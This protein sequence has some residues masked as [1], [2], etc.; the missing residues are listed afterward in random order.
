MKPF[1]A[2]IKLVSFTFIIIFLLLSNHIYS[3]KN[4]S[5][6]ERHKFGFISGYG[7]QYLWDVSYDYQIY[8]FQ[9]QYY[10]SII[11]KHTWGLEILAEPQFNTTTFKKIDNIDARTDG[12]ETGLSIGILIR[13]NLFNK[14]ISLYSFIGSGPH[15]VSGTPKRQS[16][17]FIFSDFFFIGM[18]I[19]LYKELYFDIRS[20]IRHISNAGIK[21]PNGGLNNSII[22]AGL[23][24]TL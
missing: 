2:K 21:K 13:K 14:F 24:T 6:N 3:Q 16:D 17:G 5:F 11:K 18:N 23:F 8:F 15:Y 10:Y 22:S 1:N 19:K 9:F 12:F 4:N 7:N 20:G